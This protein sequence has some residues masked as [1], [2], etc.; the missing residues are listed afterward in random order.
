MTQSTI[1]VSY[2]PLETTP[3]SDTL[4]KAGQLVTNSPIHVGCGGRAQLVACTVTPHGE[5]PFR[6]V[7]K[8]FD[9]LY[10][11]FSY[12]LAPR[13]QDVVAEADKDYAVETAA[14]RRLASVGATG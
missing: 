1:V 4:N 10:Y 5:P 14:Y 12:E 8:I 3:Y 11:R 7:T 9:A 2:P 6:A 13:P